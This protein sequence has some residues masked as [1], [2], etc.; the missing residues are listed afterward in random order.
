MRQWKL[1]SYVSDGDA[2]WRD[3]D[4]DE[5]AGHRSQQ[6]RGADER[7]YILHPVPKHPGQESSATSAEDTCHQRHSPESET[8]QGEIE[9][10]KASKKKKKEKKEQVP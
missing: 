6:A 3:E 2:C 9:D 4:G 1:V 8:A 7:V 5:E 10:S